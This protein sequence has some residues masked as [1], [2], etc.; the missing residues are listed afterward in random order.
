MAHYNHTAIEKKWREH[1][2][3]NPVNVDDGK[4]EN[5]IVWICSRIRPAA[6][7]M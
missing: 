1:W 2:A 6:V 7:F 5:I 3:Q 4:K